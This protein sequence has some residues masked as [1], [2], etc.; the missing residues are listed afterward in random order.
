M[1]YLQVFTT[2]TELET[3]VAASKSNKCMVIMV[4]YPEFLQKCKPEVLNKIELPPKLLANSLV[5]DGCGN[6]LYIGDDSRAVEDELKVDEK[7]FV[8]PIECPTSAEAII[9][10][11][12]A[13]LKFYSD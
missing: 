2:K 6:A 11:I 7:Y 5:T 4:R 1:S 13:V 3:Y 12:V 10:N 8:R 9:A